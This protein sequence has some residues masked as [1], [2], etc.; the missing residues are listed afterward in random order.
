LF[1]AAFV[2]GKQLIL[3]PDDVPDISGLLLSID[4]GLVELWILVVAKCHEFS[5]SRRYCGTYCILQLRRD[6]LDLVTVCLRHQPAEANALF[7]TNDLFLKDLI[8]FYHV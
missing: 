1:K 8:G 5:L 6:L 4:V 7:I 2:S 3:L